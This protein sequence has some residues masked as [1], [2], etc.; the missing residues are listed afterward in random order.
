MQEK[1]KVFY[2]KFLLNKVKSFFFFN[3][4][5]TLEE[6][7]RMTRNEIRNH[8]LFLDSVKSSKSRR[9]IK[10]ICFGLRT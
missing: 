3:R 10:D 4:T 2:S 9:P 5:G 8:T 6:L 7:N 1:A